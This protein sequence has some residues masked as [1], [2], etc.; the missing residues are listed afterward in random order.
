MSRYLEIVLDNWQD[1]HILADKISSFAFRGQADASWELTTS[2]ERCFEKYNPVISIYENKEHW[3]LHEFREKFHLYSNHPP[4]TINHFE[5]L[6]LLQHHGCPTRL[7]DFTDSLYIASYF[8][9]SESVTDAAIWAI[10][11]H[12]LGNRLHDQL[13]LPYDKKNSL[14]DE[15]NIHHVDLINRYIANDSNNEKPHFVIPLRSS[16]RSIRLSSQQGLFIAPI[17]M[18]NFSGGLHFM[19][20]LSHSFGSENVI[21]FSKVGLNEFDKGQEYERPS[22]SI[23]II[24]ITLPIDMHR[25]A[26]DNLSKMNLTEETLFPGL[27]GLARS[28]VHTEIRY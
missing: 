24:K 10:N 15:T 7:L 3:V 23:D 18:G 19:K 12:S 28:L 20:N 1:I 17:N 5:W 22:D 13:K 8:A 6:A 25:Q 4:D 9:I 26:I 14:K 16:K 21:E 27:D 11:L 2:L